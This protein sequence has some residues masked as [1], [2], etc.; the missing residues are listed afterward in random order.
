MIRHIVAWN[1]VA[2]DPAER[3]TAF[4]QVKA[5]LEGL[6]GVVPGLRSISVSRDVGATAGNWDI[7]L[8]SEHD[9]EEALA[10]YQQHP[11]HVVAAG[12]TRS[13][14]KDRVSVDVEV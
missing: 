2:T 5:Q 7:V 8:V 1:L 12:F 13:V 9:D 4:E 11:D 6:G 3:T 14:T 10:V